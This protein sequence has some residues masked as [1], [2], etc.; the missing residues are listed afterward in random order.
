MATLPNYTNQQRL[1]AVHEGMFHGGESTYNKEPLFTTVGAI[2]ERVWNKPV[3]RDGKQI[4]ALQELADTKTIALRT[5]AKMA[6]LLSAIQTL[7]A[8]QGQDPA[9]IQAAV[10]TGVKNALAG[11]T[12]T[13]TIG[14]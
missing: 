10:E 3:I 11:L 12:A 6:G 2:P 1:T 5:E 13:V 14:E 8:G 9:A 4:S 7:A